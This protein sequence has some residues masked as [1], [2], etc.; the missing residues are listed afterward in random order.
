[1]VKSPEHAKLKRLSFTAA[2]GALSIAPALGVRARVV[3]VV[4]RGD[5]PG[6]YEADVT[7]GRADANGVNVFTFSADSATRDLTFFIQ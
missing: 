1:M 4:Q 7:I 6:T 2:L 3:R 5:L